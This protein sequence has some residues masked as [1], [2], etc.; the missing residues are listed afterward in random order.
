MPKDHVPVLVHVEE[1]TQPQGHSTSGSHERYKSE[2]RM[3][4]AAEYDCI[5]QFGRFLVMEGAATQDELDAIRKEAKKQ[6][7]QEQKAAW[8]AFGPQSMRRWKRPLLRSK[9][10]NRVRL[11]L[12]LCATVFPR[13]CG[14]P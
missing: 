4:W 10:W 11:R 8:A 2:E 13:S 14:V 1:V 9:L 5:V 7:R 12:R 3:A 6:V